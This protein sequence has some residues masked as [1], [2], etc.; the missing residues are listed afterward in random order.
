MIKTDHG[1]INHGT[2]YSLFMCN[3][4]MAWYSLDLTGHLSCAF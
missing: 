4:T 1:T 3:P 2:I